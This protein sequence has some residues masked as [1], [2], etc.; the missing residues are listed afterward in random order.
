MFKL[1]Q[2]VAGNWV[3][4]TPNPEERG[5]ETHLAEFEMNT[6]V[7]STPA[8]EAL[9]SAAAHALVALVRG[10]VS[11]P[12]DM[13]LIDTYT[14]VTSHDTDAAARMEDRVKKAANALRYSVDAF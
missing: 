13:Q 2:T 14:Q 11:D 9:A 1:S 6:T 8:G 3:I 5:W 4:T 12:N 7:E 10:I